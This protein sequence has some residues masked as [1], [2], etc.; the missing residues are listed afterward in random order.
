M[1]AMSLRLEC[2][3]MAHAKANTHAEAVQWSEAYFNYVL[4]GMPRP[5]LKQSQEPT[6]TE[7]AAPKSARKS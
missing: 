4:N 6:P 7:K 3:R 2:L 5:E 1:D